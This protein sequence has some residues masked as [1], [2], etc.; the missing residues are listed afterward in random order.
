MVV[1][2]CAEIRFGSGFVYNR[3]STV[4]AEVLISELILFR[5]LQAMAIFTARNWINRYGA[6]RSLNIN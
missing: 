6:S 5:L 1:S 4:A 2:K 3:Y